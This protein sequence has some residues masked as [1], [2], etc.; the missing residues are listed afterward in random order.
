[1]FSNT[2]Q[3]LITG[4]LKNG[5]QALDGAF[6]SEISNDLDL[7]LNRCFDEKLNYPMPMTDLP[8]GRDWFIPKEYQDMDIESYLVSVCPKENYNRLTEEL[9]LYRK[10]GFLDVLKAMKYLVDTLRANKIVWGVG[11]GSSVSSYCLYLI[12]IHKI[13]SVKY[14]LPISDFFKGE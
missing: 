12:G 2:D 1:M 3:D 13:D 10:N 11:R 4:I 6:V 9:E 5:P 14:R 8:K 7:Y